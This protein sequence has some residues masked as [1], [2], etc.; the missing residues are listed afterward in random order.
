MHS[1]MFN[2]AQVPLETIGL[3]DGCIIVEIVIKSFSKLM[4]LEISKKHDG[5][6][7]EKSPPPVGIVLR[8]SVKASFYNNFDKTIILKNTFITFSIF[9]ANIVTPLLNCFYRLAACSATPTG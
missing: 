4:L 1:I 2:L 6:G 8:D 3:K 7:G 5:K 9:F